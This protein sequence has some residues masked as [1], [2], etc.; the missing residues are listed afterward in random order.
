MKRFAIASWAA[1]S[2]ISV[3]AQ[4]PEL[5]S[6]ADY[7]MTEVPMDFISAINSN[8][9]LA[10]TKKE[11]AV[12]FAQGQL[13]ELKGPGRYTTLLATDISDTGYIVGSGE[14]EGV[15][16]ALFW[17]DLT[18]EPVEISTPGGAP[19]IAGAVNTHGVVVGTY[20][21][22]NDQHGFRWSAA[23]GLT[24]IDPP[25]ARASVAIDISDSGY[26]IG[27]STY[28]TGNAQPTR[29]FPDG[30]S[31]IVATDGYPLKRVLENGSAIG[32]ISAGSAH[33]SVTNTPTLL[34][35]GF[36]VEYMSSRGRMIGTGIHESGGL[37]PMTRES[38]NAF[39]VFL[40]TPPGAYGFSR[41]VNSCGTITGNLTLATGSQQAVIWSRPACDPQTNVVVPEVRGYPIEQAT[42]VLR[43]SAVF[44]GRSTFVVNSCNFLGRV[45]DQSPGSNTEVPTA[46]TV[47][48]TVVTTCSVTMPNVRGQSLNGA[49]AAL[50]QVGLTIGQ[51]RYAVDNTCSNIGNVISQI[52]ASGTGLYWGAA[53]TVTIG[54]R[55][56]TAC[57]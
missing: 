42:H 37:K 21:L 55:P 44:A 13:H 53:V 56:R 2:S 23:A 34:G 31:H 30:H 36:G 32:G 43:Q 15:R 40:P 38:P 54:Q 20:T 16:R 35:A 48:L 33:W 45:L 6:S 39:S 47:D 3:Q 7:I 46:S 41:D 19:A 26:I 11:A 18:S 49:A 5:P 4:N 22:N 14:R 27:S 51:T 24:T 52:P 17:P 8:G 25:G 29:W 28:S 10:G 57:P 12:V 1:L 9:A 50:A